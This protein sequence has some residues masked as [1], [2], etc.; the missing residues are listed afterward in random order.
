MSSA[1]PVPVTPDLT[2]ARWAGGGAALHRLTEVFYARVRSDPLLAPVF[3]GMDSRHPAWVAQWLEEV[4]GGPATY[5]EERGGYPRM[6]G[7]HLGRALT[8]EQRAR[9]VRLM[10]EAADAVRLPADPEF[11]SAFV[12]YL[13]WGSRLALLNSQDGAAPALDAPMPRWGWGEVGGPYQ[14]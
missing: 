10:G 8:E 3:A 12:A 7:Q 13:E 11:R 5:S 6:I 4:F 2:L 14:G 1:D 9:W